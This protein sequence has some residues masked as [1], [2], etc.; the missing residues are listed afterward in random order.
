MTLACFLAAPA[1]LGFSRDT[2]G[3]PH[4]SAPTWEEAFYSAGYAVAEDR[5]WQMETSRRAAR[6]RLAEI[7]GESAAAADREVI[8]YDYTDDELKAQLAKLPDSIQSAYKAYAEGVNE[9]IARAK[10]AGTLPPKYKELG[11]EPEAWT[12]SDSV[13]ITIKFLQ[14]FGR[15]GEGEI[16]NWALAQYLGARANLKPK[17]MDV[18][19]DLA[20]FNDSRAIT[21]VSDKDDLSAKTHP[22][23][24]APSRKESEAHLASLPKVG[25]LELLPALRVASREE[26]TRVAASVSA[27]HY[28]G[29]YCVVVSKEK[30]TT[31]FPLLLSAPQMGFRNPS[32]VHE[33]SISAPGMDVV[34]MDLP[35]V[36]G[37]L[38]GHTKD[39]AWGFTTGVAD[40]VDI[41][42][43][44][45]EGNSYRDGSE[46]RPIQS[47]TR[48]LK[49]K[50]K[51]D[52]VVT[53]T[54]TADG[55]ILLNSKGAK[56]LFARRA[57]FYGRELESME[58]LYGLY[59]CKSVTDVAGVIAKATMNFNA[60][61]AL[62][63]GDIGWAYAGLI[64]HRQD[65]FDPRLPTPGSQK[66]KGLM[67]PAQLPHTINPSSGFLANWNNKPASWWPN[68]DTPVWGRIFRNQVLLD[69]LAKPKLSVADVEMAAWQIARTS[70]SWTAFRPHL[71][72]LPDSELGRRL[73][74]FD[75]K[76]LDG[77]VEALLWETVLDQLRE[78][79]F[80]EVTGNL[81]SPSNFRQAVQPSLILNA[82]E[83]KTKFDY[84]QG[85]SRS[86][87]VQLAFDRAVAALGPKLASGFDAP[88]IRLEDV[89]PIPYSNRGTY[90][91]IIELGETVRGRNVLPPGVAESGTHSTD[92]ANLSRAWVY[93]PMRFVP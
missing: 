80:L 93:K 66:W 77:S 75:G 78:V 39:A 50:G 56:T 49:V 92:Q 33:M 51:P 44:P 34:G 74:N 10:Q 73:K 84:L 58:A 14:Q 70:D 72:S 13:A 25:L 65:G 20:W 83:G 43:Y 36:P 41:V 46:I 9:Y 37:V 17:L 55:P 7:L 86:Q 81:T 11:F 85:R 6:G 42:H 31:G 62:R 19:D 64:P 68:W 82:L 15:G 52:E 2:Y 1:L 12:T 21:T 54:R 89:P 22:R 48:E 16:R 60:F 57:A 35:G 4:I 8:K 24:A 63:S 61:F 32:I 45:V 76:L 91:Q 27:P 30:S 40:T 38:I 71:A 5:L 87:V 23:F 26:T 18:M 28:S 3:V 67:S 88:A 47:L 69:Q 53:Q 29:S 79:L 90:I 59:R